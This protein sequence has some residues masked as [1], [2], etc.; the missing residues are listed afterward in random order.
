MVSKPFLLI[1]SS[2]YHFCMKHNLILES[3]NLLLTYFKKNKDLK[4]FAKQSKLL[5]QSFTSFSP[6]AEF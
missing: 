6:I 5:L 3:T 1:R 2:H 4:T